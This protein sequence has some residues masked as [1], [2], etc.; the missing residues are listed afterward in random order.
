[1]NDTQNELS[2]GVEEQ[3]AAEES[4]Y[5]EGL[6]PVALFDALDEDGLNILVD[7]AAR[8]LRRYYHL[9]T[10]AGEGKFS[11]EVANN[12]IYEFHHRLFSV[13]AQDS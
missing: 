9:L 11:D 8:L 1:M 2:V 12:L 7:Q 3:I 13:D 10:A 4:A 6:T 5:A